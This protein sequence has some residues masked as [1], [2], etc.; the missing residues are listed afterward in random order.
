M[1]NAVQAAVSADSMIPFE[2]ALPKVAW[3]APKFPLFNTPGRTK[4]EATGHDFEMAP[5][6]KRTTVR[7]FRHALAVRPTSWHC[8]SG[9]HIKQ[10]N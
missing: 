3:V 4:G 1:S 9:P 7:T 8:A 10:N 6:A 2:N 5:P